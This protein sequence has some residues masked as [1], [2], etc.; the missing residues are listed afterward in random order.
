MTQKELVL[1][2]KLLVGLNLSY[3]RLIKQKQLEDGNLIFTEN[4]QIVKIKARELN[5]IVTKS[6]Q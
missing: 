1:R 4:G 3:A 6:L 5:Q 2:N